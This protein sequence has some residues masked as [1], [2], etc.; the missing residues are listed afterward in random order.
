MRIHWNVSEDVKWDRM[1]DSTIS[2]LPD[3]A[4]P[5]IVTRAFMRVKV[6]LF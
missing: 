2:F 4:D 6:L 5:R 3:T 1:P